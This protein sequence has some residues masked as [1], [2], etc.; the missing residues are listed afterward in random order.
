MAKKDKEVLEEVVEE[1][2]EE[3]LEEAEEAEEVGA[4]WKEV[5]S[6]LKEVVAKLDSIDY[7]FQKDEILM[8]RQ[9]FNDKE[10]SEELYN[11]IMSL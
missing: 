8:I 4:D 6:K 10:R 5:A 2:E 9:R 3:V 7:Y 1:V 11:K